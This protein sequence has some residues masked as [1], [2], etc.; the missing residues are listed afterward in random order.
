MRTT[1]RG[2]DSLFVG[3]VSSEDAEGSLVFLLLLPL[4]DDEDEPDGTFAGSTGT[5]NFARIS[6]SF[7]ASSS[8]NSARVLKTMVVF[9]RVKERVCGKDLAMCVRE[10]VWRGGSGGV[11]EYGE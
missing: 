4:E 7:A 1:L 10:C 8:S 3:D 11:A 2:A 5:A 6:F 9:F